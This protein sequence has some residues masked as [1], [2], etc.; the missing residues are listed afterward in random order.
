MPSD[1]TNKCLTH[2]LQVKYSGVCKQYCNRFVYSTIIISVM[3]F[4]KLNKLLNEDY[5]LSMYSMLL[6][7]CTNFANLV[8]LCLTIRGTE[9]HMN[10]KIKPMVI[11]YWA[12][13]TLNGVIIMADFVIPHLPVT[14]HIQHIIYPTQL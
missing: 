6:P 14:P 7:G 4:E 2:W 1:F 13:S 9:V 12:H 8:K 5:A 3:G 11:A 10:L